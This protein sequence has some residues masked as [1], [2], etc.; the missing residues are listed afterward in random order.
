MII[1]YV[2]LV[3]SSKTAVKSYSSISSD[4]NSSL[5]RVQECLKALMSSDVRS[6][7][8]ESNS[9][10]GDCSSESGLD[11]DDEADE[12]AM[13]RKVVRSKRMTSAA[14]QAAAKVVRCLERIAAFGMRVCT[15]LDQAWR[16][17]SCQTGLEQYE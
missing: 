9:D 6:Y 1:T 10:V 2:F 7:R 15:M 4:R 3:I 5:T 16:T 8:L 12:V 13:T 17:G 14:L 11:R